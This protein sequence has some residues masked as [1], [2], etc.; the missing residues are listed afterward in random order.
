MGSMMLGLGASV[1]L[2]KYVKKCHA[3]FYFMLGLVI[4]LVEV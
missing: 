2:K 3:N 4:K 1:K